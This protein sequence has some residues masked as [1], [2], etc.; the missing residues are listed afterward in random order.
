M[1]NITFKTRYQR[2]QERKVSEQKRLISLAKENGIYI[3]D[4]FRPSEVV[5][6]GKKHVKGMW[7]GWYTSLDARAKIA[8]REL[9][10][11]GLI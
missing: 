10:K 9:K 7:Y 1:F 11:K 6:T 3:P 2:E 5:P 4:G 8:E